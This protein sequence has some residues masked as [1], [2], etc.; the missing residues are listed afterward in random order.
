MSVFNLYTDQDPIGT[1]HPLYV[2]RMQAAVHAWL[3]AESGVSLGEAL[4]SIRSRMLADFGDIPLALVDATI[5]IVYAGHGALHDV[6]VRV[7]PDSVRPPDPP[8]VVRPYRYARGAVAV[9]C[10]SPDGIKTRAAR[11]A[12]HVGGR[13]VQRARGYVMSPRK[14]ERLLA[15]FESGR[16]AC[17]ITRAL[18]P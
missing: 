11:L 14:A 3:A 6:D 17:V 4:R 18:L 1:D 2:A 15:L 12:E 13:W 5:S 8:P 16:D 7:H 10:P 9:D